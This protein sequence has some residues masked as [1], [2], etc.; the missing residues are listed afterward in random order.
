MTSTVS[1]LMRITK[2]IYD[3][4]RTE[5]STAVAAF[6]GLPAEQAPQ[7]LSIKA[8]Y[9]IILEL[10]SDSLLMIEKKRYVSSA[11]LLRSLFEYYIDLLFLAKDPD[12]WKRLKLDAKKEQQKII[13][14]IENSKEPCI[15]KLKTDGRFEPKKNELK[16]DLKDHPKNKLSCIDK[17]EQKWMY[18]MVYRPLSTVAHPSIANYDD[19]YFKADSS[20]KMFEY[21]PAPQLN[22]EDAI[23]GL[24]LL[25]K[26]LIDSTNC[27]Y[28]ILPNCKTSAIEA[29]LEKFSQ[30]L[31]Q[32]NAS[33]I[34]SK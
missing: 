34:L 7:L 26:I 14:A 33:G 29:K 20:G 32:T 24:V 8:V 25:S 1:E 9:N 3:Y 30:K 6:K 2:G 22:E 11:A 18:D 23:R 10:A 15:A 31:I 12:N 19:R 5:E 28:Q 17:T 27:I 16:N 21:Q 13:N 4:C